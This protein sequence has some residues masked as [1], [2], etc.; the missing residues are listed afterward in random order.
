MPNPRMKIQIYDDG[1]SCRQFCEKEAGSLNCN[2]MWYL[3]LVVPVFILCT[4]TSNKKPAAVS[5][6][7]L[8]KLPLILRM[9]RGGMNVCLMVPII[10]WGVEQRSF[11]ESLKGQ[12]VRIK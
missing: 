5:P 2:K 10:R 9:L 1:K 8:E 3:N 6:C 12:T 4:V 7:L 11:N